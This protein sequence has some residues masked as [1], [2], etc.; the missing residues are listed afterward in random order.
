MDDL[1]M[2]AQAS[3]EAALW[4]PLVEKFVAGH[5]RQVPRRLPRD[6]SD[7]RHNYVHVRDTRVRSGCRR[8][9][10]DRD[11]RATP[12]AVAHSAPGRRLGLA[13]DRHAG[14]PRAD[15]F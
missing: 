11:R 4:C 6:Q 15:G 3:E 1:M 9:V 5:P 13:D 12:P 8:E 2:A 7:R 10:P 14:H